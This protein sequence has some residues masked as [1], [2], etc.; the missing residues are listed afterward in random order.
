[1]RD[2]A[3]ELL[4]ADLAAE[5]QQSSSLWIILLPSNALHYDTEIDM[6]NFF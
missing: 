3:C 6:L 1:M 5:P 4:I 2:K